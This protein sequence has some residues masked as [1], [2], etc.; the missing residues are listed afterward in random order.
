MLPRVAVRKM[1]IGG[2]QWGASEP[3]VLPVTVP[4][5]MLWTPVGTEMRWA[6]GTFGSSL[7]QLHFWWSGARYFISA[8]Y[9]NDRFAG[10]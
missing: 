4:F 9:A 10:G 3:Y 2:K 6:T 1:Q 5:T 8:H 7:N